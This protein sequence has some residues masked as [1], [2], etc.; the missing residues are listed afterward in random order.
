MYVTDYNHSLQHVDG[1][2]TFPPPEV[3]GKDKPS[4]MVLMLARH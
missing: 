2:L 4:I 1:R 3:V